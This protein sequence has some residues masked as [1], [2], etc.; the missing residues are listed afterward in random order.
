MSQSELLQ[1]R[2]MLEEKSSQVKVANHITIKMQALQ[3]GR[4][5]RKLFLSFKKKHQQ[6]RELVDFLY[7]DKVLLI[8]EIIP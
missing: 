5:I 8:I 2:C 6:N 1:I 3:F 4:A 7:H